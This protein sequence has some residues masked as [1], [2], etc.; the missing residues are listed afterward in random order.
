MDLRFGIFVF[1]RVVKRLELLHLFHLLLSKLVEAPKVLQVPGTLQLLITKGRK[2][3][4]D[5]SG[6][7]PAGRLVQ[8]FNSWLQVEGNNFFRFL[9]A[10]SG[11]LVTLVF[12]S[13]R[14]A[15]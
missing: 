9:E 8:L 15:Q 4:K 3:V 10:G 14:V 1:C 7:R 2:L 12:V 13:K 5:L 6:F 11:Y